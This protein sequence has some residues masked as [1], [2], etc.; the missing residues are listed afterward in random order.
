M[1]KLLLLILATTC[2]TSAGLSLRYAH[3]VRSAFVGFSNFHTAEAKLFID[4][5]L[6]EREQADTLKKLDSARKRIEE[7]FGAMKADP[8]II[9]AGD[10]ETA[11]RYGVNDTPASSS[12]VPWGIYIVVNQKQSSIDVFAHE[13]VHA[14]IAE[15]LGYI[16]RLN[17]LPTWFDEGVA[18]QVDHRAHYMPS[19]KAVDRTEISR[20]KQ[21]QN[22]SRFWS[23]DKGQNIRNYQ[24]AKAAVAEL[25]IH[26]PPA[27][28]YEKLEKMRMGESL[29]DIY[30]T[31]Y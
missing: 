30:G 26:N 5:Q 8:V 12:F 17:N 1:K 18:M 27:T 10:A 29:S 3:I 25:F 9:I 19:Y 28:L 14:E 20:V 2:F 31:S 7:T 4:Y 24:A 13:L 21:L 6:N 22:P 15:R 23:A 16:R 11:N